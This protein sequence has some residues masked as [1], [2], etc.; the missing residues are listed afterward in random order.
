MIR[1]RFLAAGFC[2]PCAIC[3]CGGAA[4]ASGIAPSVPVT[5]YTFPSGKGGTLTS[6]GFDAVEGN[7]F[8]VTGPSNVSVTALGYEYVS[9]TQI[10]G[11]TGIL[12]ANGNLLTSTSFTS[13]DTI[14]NGYYWRNIQPVTLV[15]GQEYYIGAV[16]GAGAAY[17]Y[18]W[19]TRTA[20]VP[21]NISDMGTYFKVSD[22][23]TVGNWQFGG[24]TSQYGPGEIRHYV[25]N[26][27]VALPR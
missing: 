6:P 22:S 10:I 2:L 27:K 15:A 1:F 7:L 4:S 9:P 24:G 17:T 25:A 14:E 20:T 21:G 5:V 8:K 16:H 12:D 3:G 23:F 11:T 13:S 26:F 18:Y 19:N